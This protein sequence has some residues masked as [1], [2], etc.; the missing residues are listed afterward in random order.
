MVHLLNTQSMTLLSQT[1]DKVHRQ[2]TQKKQTFLSLRDRPL[3]E[4]LSNL[5]HSVQ[6]DSEIKEEFVESQ[7]SKKNEKD[8]KRKCFC[9]C[10]PSNQGR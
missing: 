10:K 4:L 7:L 1:V 6:D 5:G 8:R 9:N 2:P 3:D